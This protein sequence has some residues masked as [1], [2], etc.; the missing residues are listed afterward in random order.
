MRTL[1]LATV[2]L[3]GAPPAAQQTPVFTAR[4]E[5]VRVDAL[6]TGGDRRPVKGLNP[7]DF[8]IKDNGVLQKV[9]LVTFGDVALN[10]VLAFDVSDSVA[11][12]RMERLRLASRAL[13]GLLNPADQ[14]SLVTFDRVVSRPCPLAVNVACLDTAL[15]SPKPG[16]ETAL[17]DGAFAGM[18]VGESDVGRSLLIVFSDGID[19]ASWL[20]ADRV[21]DLA[22]RSDVVVYAV[23]SRGTRPDFL[24]DLTSL[25][26]GRLYE[27]ERTDDVSTIFKNVLEEFRG[28][29]LLTYTP[30]GVT[31]EGWHK[32]EVKVKRGGASVKAR[33]G[34]QGS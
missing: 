10:V 20:S 26:A 24:K 33:P 22:R 2:V 11:G 4:V 27:V 5:G 16:R 9:D 32:L 28:R 14:A 7:E 13:T 30:N 34:Y 29:Y 1:L 15:A 25:S 12:A 19:T 6:V 31:R 23:A 21:L 3:S 18:M 17:I 8:E